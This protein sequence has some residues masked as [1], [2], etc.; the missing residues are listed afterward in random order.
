MKQVISMAENTKKNWG[1]IAAMILSLFAFIAF[2]PGASKQW[3]QTGAGLAYDKEL[4]IAGLTHQQ[5]TESKSH[6]IRADRAKR[7]GIIYSALMINGTHLPLL[8]YL[9][10]TVIIITT[11]L[12]QTVNRKLFMLF[13]VFFI[14]GIA[15]SAFAHI[16]ISP[17]SIT[18]AFLGAFVIWIGFT[19]IFL[20]VLFVGLFVRRLRG[21]RLVCR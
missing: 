6:D 10:L 21:S 8:F 2:T 19:V 17:L 4:K 20:I 1:R 13:P 11:P 5:S 9:L 14:W 18:D 12:S 7:N 15:F 16:I 3:Y